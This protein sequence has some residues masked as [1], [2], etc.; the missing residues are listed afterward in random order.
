MDIFLSKST[1]KAL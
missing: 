1:F